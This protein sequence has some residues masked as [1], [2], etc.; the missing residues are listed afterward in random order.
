MKCFYFGCWNQAGHFLFLPGGR[1][2]REERLE[3]YGGAQHIHLD[4]SLA[5]RITRDGAII[6]KGAGQ[7]R[8]IRDRLDYSSEEAPQGQYLLHVLDTGY[9]AIQWW[10][11]CQ[12]DTRGACNSTVLLEGTHTADE[13]I[14]AL[15][16]HFPHVA[17]NLAKAGVELIEVKKP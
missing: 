6:W 3:M 7:T 14:A 13:M 2:A 10:D 11:R 4:G 15:H 16:E 8:E 1:S 17:A 9:T 12:G 5:P